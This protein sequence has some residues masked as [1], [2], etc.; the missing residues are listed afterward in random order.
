MALIAPR[1]ILIKLI[2]YKTITVRNR[3][4][5]HYGLVRVEFI[6]IHPLSSTKNRDVIQVIIEYH[7]LMGRNEKR[8][9]M[10]EQYSNSG[11]RSGCI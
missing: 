7:P 3:F 5:N 4:L 6:Y 2:L 1:V 10:Q 9:F 11:R 8:F